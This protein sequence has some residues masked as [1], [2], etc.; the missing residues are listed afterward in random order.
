MRC[1]VDKRSRFEDTVSKEQLLDTAFIRSLFVRELNEIKGAVADI[2]NTLDGRCKKCN[3]TWYI[4]FMSA[5]ALIV[6]LLFYTWIKAI[7]AKDRV[8]AAVAKAGIEA[9]TKAVK[10]EDALPAGLL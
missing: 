7:E 1:V 3:N 10:I 4:R 8:G 6:I 9:I 5:A 2:R